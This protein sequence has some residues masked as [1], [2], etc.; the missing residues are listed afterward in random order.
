MT[1]VAA[2]E[3]QPV[4]EILRWASERLGPRLTRHGFGAEGCVLIDDRAGRRCR[5]TC[6]ARHR[7]A[8]PRDLRA[9]APA[10]GDATAITIRAVRPEHT[11]DAQALVTARRCGRAIRIAA[12]RCARSA[13]CARRSR[14]ST[15][16]SPAIRREQTPERADRAGR[17]ARPASSA[18][19]RSTRSS[20]GPT[21]TCGRTSTRTTSRTTSCTI[22]GYPSIGCEPCTSAVAPGESP[23]AGRWRGAAKTEC[24]LHAL[25]SEGTR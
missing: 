24:G 13:R 20:R 23:R 22:A 3:G 16:G 2:K 8:V 4:L 1:D 21:T 25:T 12:A 15:R 10:R 18:C 5:S 14:A 6:Y 9:V 17:R 11:I 7:R 19:S